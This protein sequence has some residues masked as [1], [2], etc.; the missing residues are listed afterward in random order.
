MTVRPT[1][2]TSSHA[3]AFIPT[4]SRDAGI[5]ADQHRGE[6]GRPAA[7]GAAAATS[8]ATSAR[9]S[10]ATAAVEQPVVEDRSPGAVDRS[11]LPL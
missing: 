5:V 7:G 9:I 4:Y 11:S 1:I 2:P 8:S 10:A 3:F 6:P